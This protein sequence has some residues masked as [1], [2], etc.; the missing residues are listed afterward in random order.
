MSFTRPDTIVIVEDDHAICAM[1]KFKLEKSGFHVETAFDG[2][3]GL[4]VIEKFLP[5]LIL[6]DLK[7][8]IMSG[9]EMLETLRTTKWGSQ[10]RVIVLTNISKDEAP[11]NLRLLH[12]NRYIVK[13]HHTPNQV[14]EIVQEVLGRHLK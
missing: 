8:P 2:R 12:V 3:E 1:Y 5:D 14:V 13:A 10:V 7:M 9:D 11:P 6:L 4:L